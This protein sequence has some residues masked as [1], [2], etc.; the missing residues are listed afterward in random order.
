[1]PF[2]HN[3]PRRHHIKPM[4]YKVMNWKSYNNALK[5]R[6]NI[7]IWFDDKAIRNWYAKHNGKPGGQRTYSN[8][9]IETASIIRLVFHLPLRQT[10]GFMYSLT[11][12]M[13]IDLRIPDFS[14]LSRRI[15]KLAVKLSSQATHKP[16]THIIIDG[17]GL[18][19]HG[20][21]E[22]RQLQN[23]LTRIKGYRRLHVAINEHQ[24]IT[25]CELTT[26][27]GNEKKQVPKLLR[28]IHDHCECIMADKNYDDQYVYSAIEKYRPTCYVRP[29]KRD[30]YT[31]VIPPHS[32][33]KIR[34]R[35]RRYPLERS[36]HAEIIKDRG[37]MYWQ[38]HTGYGKR[39]LVEVAFSRYKRIFGKQ[40]HAIDLANQKAEAKLACKALN[41]MSS[42]GMPETIRV[43]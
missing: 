30:T 40:M 39:S 29:V 8:I 37:M 31:V 41:I 2:K 38:K 5:Q 25:A 35:K 12:L 14:T 28:K 32:N 16:G 10:E 36:H 1:M 24:E 6:G 34:K 33:A 27:R 18:S 43:F 22:F 21:D 42:L 7:T 19:T 23:G 11:K 9:E 3:N 26:I 17:S 13:N 20:A 15:R 4:K